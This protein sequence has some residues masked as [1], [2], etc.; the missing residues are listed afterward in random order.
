MP[1]AS[2]LSRATHFLVLPFP[3]GLLGCGQVEAGPSGKGSC[4]LQGGA[5]PGVGKEGPFLPR[6]KPESGRGWK[7]SV[8]VGLGLVGAPGST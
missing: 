7:G 2:A 6:K 1:A 5:G 8:S 4:P 3:V